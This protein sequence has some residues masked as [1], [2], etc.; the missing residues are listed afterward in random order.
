MGTL[1]FVKLRNEK[2]KLDGVRVQTFKF[3]FKIIPVMDYDMELRIFVKNLSLV[4]L[5]HKVLVLS[6]ILLPN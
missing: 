2:I 5:H 1:S 3:I 4:H 6:K